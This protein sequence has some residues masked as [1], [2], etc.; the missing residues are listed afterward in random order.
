MSERRPLRDF[1]S[2]DERRAVD[3]LD[4]IGSR[5]FPLPMKLDPMVPPGTLELHDEKGIVKRVSVDQA[6]TQEQR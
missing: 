4:G 2:D 5:P 3:F 1:M 6:Y